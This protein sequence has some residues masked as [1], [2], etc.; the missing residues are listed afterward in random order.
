MKRLQSNEPKGTFTN[1]GS[2]GCK[3]GADVCKRCEGEC[4]SDDQCQDGLVCFNRVGTG[5]VPG[6][7]GSG[8]ADVGYC[9]VDETNG[10]KGYSFTAK[11]TQWSGYTRLFSELYP[12]L[13]I[14]HGGSTNSFGLSLVTDN[15]DDRV[16]QESSAWAFDTPQTL[17]DDLNKCKQRC[18][19]LL[20][21]NYITYWDRDGESGGARSDPLILN[22]CLLLSTCGLSKT[23]T[24]EG[25][26]WIRGA[27]KVPDTSTANTDGKETGM[28]A[29]S[30]NVLTPDAEAAGDSNTTT[31]WEEATCGAS[32]ILHLT[33]DTNIDAIALNTNRA[34]G[35]KSYDIETSSHSSLGWEKFW[36]WSPMDSWP[37]DENDVFGYSHGHCKSSDSYCFQR[38]PS[39]LDE[40]YTELR[41]VEKDT[42][43]KIIGSLTW[44]F[45]PD[46]NVA[47]GVWKA[48]ALGLETPAGTLLNKDNW[49]PTIESN[50]DNKKDYLDASTFAEKFDSFMYRVEGGV[51]SLLLADD[52]CEC[53]SVLSLGHSMCDGGCD[54]T[55]CI[56]T[57]YGVDTLLDVK[58]DTCLKPTT[59]DRTIELHYR[60][61]RESITWD[62]VTQTMSLAKMTTDNRW[63]T[64]VLDTML[65]ARYVRLTTKECHDTKTT[66]NEIRLLAKSKSMGIDAN[67][68]AVDSAYRFTATTNA[69]SWTTNEAMRFEGALYPQSSKFGFA[70][71]MSVERGWTKTTGETSDTKWCTSNYQ[72]FTTVKSV[73]ECRKRCDTVP[74]DVCLEFSYSTLTENCRVS[75][76]LSGCSP[77][78]PSDTS[79][80]YIFYR[81]NAF[82]GI[83]SC[84]TSGTDCRF[85]HDTYDNTC[86]SKGSTD[87][88][89][90]P[91]CQYLDGTLHNPQ[92]STTGTCDDTQWY[93]SGN[94][95]TYR[96]TLHKRWMRIYFERPAIIN[97]LLFKH[98]SRGRITS[99]RLSCPPIKEG[100]KLDSLIVDGSAIDASTGDLQIITLPRP[101]L[102]PSVR[103]EIIAPGNGAIGNLGIAHLLFMSP[104]APSGITIEG[105]V[106]ASSIGRPSSAATW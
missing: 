80:K 98:G 10:K 46:N 2:V 83:K 53:R 27:T 66:I 43:G 69:W 54:G 41:A 72:E 30:F 16:Q 56:S 63:H 105:W 20:N 25:I 52:N 92:I 8:V 82:V 74:G 68:L 88:S 33:R 51:R 50:D 17:T 62:A 29:L 67:G 26:S 104:R 103:I 59:K 19:T 71:T 18:S 11:T 95:D 70:P 57:G 60:D 81:R 22:R 89:N 65:A 38:F 61:T 21:C 1:S 34:N 36:W 73:E 49:A 31:A 5:A 101:M 37:H 24:A 85:S 100:G 12:L 7:E 102:C 23:T 93:V 15:T 45:D 99:M 32:V 79:Q 9:V 96:D 64:L 94:D 77:S 40:M 91:S 48:M 39:H 42:T 90:A 86:K 44:K 97:R 13:S 76:V 84:E 75:N 6:C 3:T 55:N 106:K 58:D 47:H 87:C 14:A 28:N 35:I 78:N 4:V